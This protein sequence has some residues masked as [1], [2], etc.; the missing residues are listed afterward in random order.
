MY[1]ITWK[2]S[3]NH[4]DGRNGY[5]PEAIVNHRMVGTL[6]GTDLTFSKPA[7]EV[8]T[9]FGIGKRTVNG[10]VEISQYVDLSD[11]A[12]GNG[13]ADPETTW[14]LLKRGPAGI[15]NPN[16]YTVSIEHEDGGS[17]N[18]GLVK[19]EIIDASVWL[20]R[21]LL[22]GSAPLMRAAGIRIRDDATA[23]ALKSIVPGNETYID[24]RRIAGR[25]KP[26]CWRP[27][28]GDPGFVPYWK[29]IMLA[30]LQEREMTIDEIMA[31][32]QTE[33]DR[34]E[35]E[36]DNAV[37]LWTNQKT[38]TDRLKGLLLTVK[39]ETRTFAAEIEAIQV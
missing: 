37:A 4:Y 3:P 17:A 30:R 31:L 39:D 19:P 24:H 36:R 11:G 5:Q 23:A 10:P 13:N 15:I 32:L 25:A 21:L 14:P 35:T 38:E 9:H 27:W 28:L 20:S 18:R 2:N 22:S 8:S 16:Y 33:I 7:N 1:T 6:P 26:D 29:P 34:L 12:W